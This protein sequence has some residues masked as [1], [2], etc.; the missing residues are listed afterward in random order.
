MGCPKQLYVE[1]DPATDQ[2][3]RCGNTLAVELT[4]EEL[5]AARRAGAKV[6]L[7]NRCG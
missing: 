3:P 5:A 7:A 2:C 1:I 4:E 6:R